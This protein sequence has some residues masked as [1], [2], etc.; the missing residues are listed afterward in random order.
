DWVLRQG[1]PVHHRRRL[2]HVVLPRA[3][4]AHDGYLDDTGCHPWFPDLPAGPHVLPGGHRHPLRLIS[5]RH[6]RWS[7]PMSPFLGHA[8]LPVTACGQGVPP[9]AGCLAAERSWVL[10]WALVGSS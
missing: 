5:L 8:A 1:S 3:V 7:V 4:G 2:G 6:L 10:A 9:A